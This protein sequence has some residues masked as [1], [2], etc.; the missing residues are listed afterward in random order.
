MGKVL[1]DVPVQATAD[2]IE[3]C[4]YEMIGTKAM[5]S[6]L[7]LDYTQ[8]A[9]LNG[10]FC[11]SSS[12]M[13]TDNA[14]GGVHKCLLQCACRQD[15]NHVS[16]EYD[17]DSGGSYLCSFHASKPGADDCTSES[18][19][20]KGTFEVKKTPTND[21][22]QPHITLQDFCPFR[23]PK[24]PTNNNAFPFTLTGTASNDVGP[25]KDAVGAHV[26]I[27]MPFSDVCD[28]SGI[29]TIGA[30]VNSMYGSWYA[31]CKGSLTSHE[32]GHNME[33]E[34]AGSGDTGSIFE[35]YGDESDVMGDA[36]LHT[37]NAPHVGQLGWLQKNT[38]TGA[39]TDPN[40]SVKYI[41]SRKG[42]VTAK[43]ASIRIAPGQ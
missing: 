4:S 23:F 40:N 38:F 3:K 17:S 34:H 19:D 21:G 11:A 30:G 24:E 5:V 10:K 2:E 26:A 39:A 15:C 8:D 1:W 13:Y 27:F 14:D 9:S 43:V 12:V 25:A 42:S 16:M 36:A 35:E 41:T 33:L 18:S 28:F 6:A 32:L 37:F 29:A 20:P 7:K 31:G 22:A